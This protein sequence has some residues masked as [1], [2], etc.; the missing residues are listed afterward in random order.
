MSRTDNLVKTVEK[1]GGK[2]EGEAR[3][4]VIYLNVTY[5]T[6]RKYETNLRKTL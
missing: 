4:I 3:Y 5:K 2:R 1:E 6:K